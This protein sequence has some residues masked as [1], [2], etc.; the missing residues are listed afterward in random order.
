MML[1]LN[2]AALIEFVRI[3]M[4]ILHESFPPKIKDK[5]PPGP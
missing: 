1:F 4:K 2:L 3:K 5:T